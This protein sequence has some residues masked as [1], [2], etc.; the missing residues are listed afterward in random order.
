MKGKNS[1]INPVGEGGGKRKEGRGEVGGHEMP[2]LI[3][4]SLVKSSDL[5]SACVQV[6]L[7]V[8]GSGRRSAGAVFC[9][10]MDRIW[11]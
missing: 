4:K 5:H 3:P 6:D 2:T 7:Y 9:A 10:W 1:P 11:N 8:W